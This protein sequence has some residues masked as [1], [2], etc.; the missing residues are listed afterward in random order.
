LV[1]VPGNPTVTINDIR[2]KRALFRVPTSAAVNGNDEAGAMSVLNACKSLPGSTAS[3]TSYR[4]GQ[5][6]TIGHPW[7]TVWNRYFHFGPP[8]M[9]S[10][11]TAPSTF[12]G[13]GGGQGVVPPTSNHPGGVN[14]CFTDGSVKFIK[15]S[16]DLKTWWALGTR[17]GGEVVS[18]D[19]Y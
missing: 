17:A 3:I 15:N 18:A 10:C 11:D 9:H 7:A 6:W 12:D 1:G 8:N 19:A 16:I 5:I 4:S 2:A 13:L 14:V